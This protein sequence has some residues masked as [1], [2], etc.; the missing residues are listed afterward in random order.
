MGYG[1]SESNLGASKKHPVNFYGSLETH[2]GTSFEVQ[3]IAIDNR[4]KQIPMYD[5]PDKKYLEQSKL[6]TESGKMEIQ[7]KE[8]PI[9][10]AVTQIDFDES[11][12]LQV[13]HEPIYVFQQKE[14][15]PSYFFHVIVISKMNGTKHDYLIPEHTKLSCDEINSAG[16]IEK[17]VPLSA[18][19]SL[20]IKGFSQRVD[21]DEQS[22]TI[23]N[24][25]CQSK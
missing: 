9:E 24:N 6:N 14:H 3:N 12:E 17:N 11:Q 13:E 22:A 10:F 5:C 18:V 1:S 15:R 4:Y 21:K 20:K 7:L 19:K 25:V 23:K 2:Q 16:P 8:N